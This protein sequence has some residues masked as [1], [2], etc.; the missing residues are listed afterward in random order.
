MAGRAR[1]ALAAK[2]NAQMEDRSWM[3]QVNCE[4]CARLFCN[5][6]YDDRKARTSKFLGLIICIQ[7]DPRAY[8]D[9]WLWRDSTKGPKPRI[10]E[11]VQ[12]RTIISTWLIRCL[13]K[14]VSVDWVQAQAAKFWDESGQPRP[15]TV[16]NEGYHP[17]QRPRLKFD[18]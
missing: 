14:G 6:N 15:I 9:R 8:D 11:E 5:N 17:A 13:A 2:N 16:P 7:C 10:A 12:Y 1:A 4:Y 3:T 18:D